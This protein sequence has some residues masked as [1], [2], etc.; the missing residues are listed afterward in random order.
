MDLEASIVIITKNRQEDLRR[1]LASCFVQDVACEVIVVDDAS[2]DG[3]SEMIH[4][5]FPT[6]RLVRHSESLGYIVRRNEAAHLANGRYI[7]SIDDDAEFTTAS[8]VR[9]ALADFDHP[10]IGAVSIPHADILVSPR[11]KTPTPAG[12]G[13]W[14]VPT[15]IGTAHALRRD[16]F[17]RLGGYRTLLVHNT[18]ERDFCIRM[19]NHGYVVRLGTGDAVYHY[20]SP[21]RDA[22]RGRML[23]RRNDICHGYWDVPL[24]HLLY[25]WPGTIINGLIYGVKT[26]CLRETMRGYVQAPAICLRS[27]RERAPVRGG[28]YRL[29]RKLNRRRLLPLEQVEPLLNIGRAHSETKL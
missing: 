2:S 4:R 23:E 11:L 27:W 10:R 22:R 13:R 3:T 6:I 20:A 18:E 17:L 9:Q 15:F 16:I 7:V 21:V 1:A 24:P 19:L 12:G 26:G 25:Y 5:D 14:I 8:V 28:I 29:F